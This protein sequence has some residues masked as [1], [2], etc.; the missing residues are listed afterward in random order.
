VVDLQQD[1]AS[2]QPHLALALT[3]LSKLQAS[4]L[5]NKKQAVAAAE[6]PEEVALAATFKAPRGG[7]EVVKGKLILPQDAA[8]TVGRS[9]FLDVAVGRFATEGN[10]ALASA[11]SEYRGKV[12]IS[13]NLYSDRAQVEGLGFLDLPRGQVQLLR[14]V[15]AEVRP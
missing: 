5:K 13:G 11:S 8:A 6:P 14:P 12:P 10:E 4:A 9:I 2:G 7:L 15:K 1:A 3:P